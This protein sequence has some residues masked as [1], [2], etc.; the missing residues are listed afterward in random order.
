MIV[1]TGAA[2]FIGSNCLVGLNQQGVDNILAV[3]D[4]TDGKKYVNLAR[5]KF[6]DYI[7]YRDFI[8]YIKQDKPFDQPIE[9]VIHQ[10][11]CSVTTEWDGRY[12]MDVNYQYSKELYH[13]CVRHGIPF[14]YASSAAVYGGNEN[15]SE[16]SDNEMPLNVYGY[17]KWLF[18]QYLARQPQAKS[19]VVGLRYFNVYGPGEAHKGGMASVAYHLTKQVIATGAVKLFGEGEGCAAGEHKR[20]FVHVED[21]VNVVLWLLDN[22]SVSGVYNL[23]T[24][25]ARSFNELADILLGLHGNGQLEYIPFPD[26]L[27]GCYQS[28]TQADISALRKAG[29]Q[30]SFLSLEDGIAAYY[31]SLV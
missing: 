7:D 26:Q 15:F 29:Y 24:G 5:A 13:Y 4:L 16:T 30:Q 2:G 20:D 9:A 3:G 19:Q 21:V 25:Q 17:S 14:I 28:F 11:A 18:D 8:E 31:K 12:M 6:A 23:G 27:K 22:P 10:G 1:V